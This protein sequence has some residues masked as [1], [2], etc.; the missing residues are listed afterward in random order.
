M[1]YQVRDLGNV[2]VAQQETIDEG[3]PSAK[4]L[5]PIAQCCAELARTVSDIVEKGQ[6]PLVLGGD[7]S[8][9]AARWPAYPTH[10]ETQSE[11]RCHLD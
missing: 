7:H 5:V 8:V 1:G 9:A 10:S 6:F 4:Y 11:N 3:S 2:P